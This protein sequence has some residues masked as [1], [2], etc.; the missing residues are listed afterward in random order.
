MAKGNQVSN[1]AS[2]AKLSIHATTALMNSASPRLAP[3][4]LITA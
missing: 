4:L 1:R 3:R 2:A